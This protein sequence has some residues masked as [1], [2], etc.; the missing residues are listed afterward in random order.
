MKYRP[1]TDVSILPPEFKI[2]Y[3]IM[4][5][6][7]LTGFRHTLIV[8]GIVLAAIGCSPEEATVAEPKTITDIILEDE[9]FSMLRAAM[10]YAGLGDTFKGGNLTLFAPTNAAFTAAGLGNDAAIRARTPGQVQAMLLYH[11]LPAPV[12]TGALPTGQNAIDMANKGTA[13]INKT[14]DA[15]IAINNA[16]ITRTNVATANGYIQVID[17]VLT[18]ST[19]NLLAAIEGNPDLTLLAAA[20]RRVGTTNT[21]IATTFSTTAT[22]MTNPATVFAP[23]NAAFQADGRFTTQTA[24]ASAN[25][26][27]LANLLLYHMV[28]GLVFSNQIQTGSLISSFNNSRFTTIVAGGLVTLKGNSNFRTGSVKTADQVANNGVLHVIDQVMLP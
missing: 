9:Q 12:E 3:T 5:R 27:T 8:L 10:N 6:F 15:V 23:N 16:S 14:S 18:P 25:Q 1:A 21:T 4:R 24:I 28:S 20:I 7:L 19:G 13:F 11:L 17:R 2:V 26:Q 22:S